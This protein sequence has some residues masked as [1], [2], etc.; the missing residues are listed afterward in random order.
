MYCAEEDLD[1]IREKINIKDYIAKKTALTKN[2][3]IYIGYCPFHQSSIPAFIID[4]ERQAY[5]CHE[6]GCSGDIFDFVMNFYHKSFSDAVCMLS[7]VSGVSI[8]RDI[9]DKHYYEKQRKIIEINQIAE[10]FYHDSLFKSA[11]ASEYLKTRKLEKETIDKFRIGYADPAIHIYNELQKLGFCDEDIMSSG[12]VAEKDRT[13]KPL[14]AKERYDKFYNR[15][16]FPI[17][18]ENNVVVGFGGRVMGDKKPK[19]INSQETSVYDK[20]AN[21]FG[22]NFAKNSYYDYFLLCEGFMDVISM[23]QTNFDNEIGRAHV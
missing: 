14:K 4:E 3:N 7:M 15:V 11:E 13:N 17:R 21:L 2:G 18:N 9:I 6:C 23:H 20:S 19:Y 8:K 12:I 22:L 1:K 5:G 16:I 10:R